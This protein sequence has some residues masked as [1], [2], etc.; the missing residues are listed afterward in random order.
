MRVPS[1]IAVAASLLLVLLPSAL[2]PSDVV[3][4]ACSAQNPHDASVSTKDGMPKIF[5]LKTLLAAWLC[6]TQRDGT[7]G[8]GVVDSS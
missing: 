4:H 1:V 5:Q 7:M 8:T 3:L 2:D 6:A